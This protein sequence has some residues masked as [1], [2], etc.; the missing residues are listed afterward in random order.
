LAR[1]K[2]PSG[3]INWPEAQAHQ[4]HTA[5][6]PSLIR[7]GLSY[8]PDIG[9]GVSVQMRPA[10]YDRLGSDTA[11]PA[12]ASLSMLDFTVGFYDQQVILEDV[13]FV[14]LE[15]HAL[16]TGLPNEPGSTWRMN[17]GL[18]QK[19][20]PCDHCWAFDG[21]FGIGKSTRLS[22]SGMGWVM[23]NATLE[24]PSDN[25]LYA[26]ID[27]GFSYDISSKWR[28]E[29]VASGKINASLTPD[30]EWDFAWNQRLTL[31]KDY[32][33]RLSVNY[34]KPLNAS[35][36]QWRTQLSSSFYF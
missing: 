26:S 23:L 16:K 7:L 2:R 28:N 27:S 29:W 11:K 30:F 25:Y 10:Y 35:E 3:K 12:Y 5:Q 9:T 14:K 6:N 34:T 15:S 24:A 18:K 22:D 19:V 21:T 36:P 33:A 1:L 8:Q 17:F 4:P 32:D 13:R 20:A 31:S